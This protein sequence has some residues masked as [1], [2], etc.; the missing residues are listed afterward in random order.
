MIANRQTKKT[1]LFQSKIIFQISEYMN[2]EQQKNSFNLFDSNQ[3]VKQSFL[4]K[5]HF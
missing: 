2:T 5:L 4:D 3:T 1:T